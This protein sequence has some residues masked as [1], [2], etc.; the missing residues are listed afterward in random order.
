MCWKLKKGFTLVEVIGILVLLTIVFSITFP[1]VTG[2]LNNSKEKLYNDQIGLIEGAAESYAIL[3]AITNNSGYLVTLTAL[4][5]EDFLKGSDVV[6]PRNNAPLTGCVL[7]E[8]NATTFA[9]TTTYQTASCG[10]GGP[11]A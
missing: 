8:Y 5:D 4:Q 10:A 3:H 1:V 11:R 7:I 6:D 2:V 9:Y